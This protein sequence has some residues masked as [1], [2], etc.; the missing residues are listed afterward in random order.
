MTGVDIAD[1]A[2]AHAQQRAQRL[3]CQLT[4]IEQDA[5]TYDWGIGEWDLIVLCYADE[6]THVAQVQAALKPGGL[7]VFENF[8][9]DINQL[10]PAASGQQI[11]FGTDELKKLYAAAA[12][13]IVRYE[14]PVGVAD[15][16]KEQHRLVRLVARKPE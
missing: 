9:A 1:Q 2:L 12:F 7:L 10:R 3:G 6:R 16:S 15:F 5:D 14:E 8:H 4:T 11:G 13:E